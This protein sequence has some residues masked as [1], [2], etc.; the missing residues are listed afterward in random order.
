MYANSNYRRQV[1]I[2]IVYTDRYI[3]RVWIYAYIF[4]LCLTCLQPWI[5]IYLNHRN[6]D[7]V[8]NREDGFRYPKARAKSKELST[9]DLI[10]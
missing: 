2:Y 4:P 5:H 8:F 1:Y 9:G 10:F 6:S 3:S 7:L